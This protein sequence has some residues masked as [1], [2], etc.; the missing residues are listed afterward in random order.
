M[1]QNEVEDEDIETTE[2]SEVENIDED[3]TTSDEKITWEEIHDLRA[4]AKSLEKAN[5]KIAFLEK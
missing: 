3:I 2:A 4:K 5:K 1:S